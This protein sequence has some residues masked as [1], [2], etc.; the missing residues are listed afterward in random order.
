MKVFFVDC[1]KTVTMMCKA[2]ACSI[3]PLSSLRDESGNNMN[4][5]ETFLNET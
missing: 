1:L 2:T 3:G 5:D 4:L